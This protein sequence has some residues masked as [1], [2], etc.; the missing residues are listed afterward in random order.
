MVEF[1][2]SWHQIDTFNYLETRPLGPVNE[3]DWVGF[4]TGE[5]E[6]Y[7]QSDL[8][9]MVN[10]EGEEEN[11]GIEGFQK[12]AD[13][14]ISKKIKRVRIAVHKTDPNYKVLGEIFNM[15]SEQKGLDLKVKI[16]IT[17]ETAEKWFYELFY[18]T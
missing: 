14:F 4:F 12:L 18:L 17:K 16:F 13:I 7:D 11:M 15:V 6:D 10:V 9:I 2:K 8:F 3:N 5:L 1:E